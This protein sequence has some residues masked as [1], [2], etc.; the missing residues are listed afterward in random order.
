MDY[1]SSDDDEFSDED[2]SSGDDSLYDTEDEI[3]LSKL[4]WDSED[5]IPLAS[6]IWKSYKA[7]D[8]DFQKF[9][10]TVSQPGFQ[11]ALS[12][13]PKYEIGYFKLFFTDELLAEIVHESENKPETTSSAIFYLA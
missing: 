8:P 2:G 12:D 3:P 4:K 13:R 9:P 5:D 6:R 1:D 7:T 11:I 10:F